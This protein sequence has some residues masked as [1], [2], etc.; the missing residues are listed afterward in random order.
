MDFDICQIVYKPGSVI[1]EVISLG[2]NSHLSSS[3]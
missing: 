1:K 2:L 3:S